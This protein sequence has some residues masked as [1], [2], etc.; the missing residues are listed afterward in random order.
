MVISNGRNTKEDENKSITNTAPH[1]HEVLDSCMGF[2]RNVS[3]HIT[4]HAHSTGNNSKEEEKMCKSKYLHLTLR[5][6]DHT[7]VVED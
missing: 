3:F 2:L 6:S 1:L 7:N 5:E 4:F